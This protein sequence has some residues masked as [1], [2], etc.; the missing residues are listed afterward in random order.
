MKFQTNR[1]AKFAL[2]V[3]TALSAVGIVSAKAASTLTSPETSCPT[4]YAVIPM[5]GCVDPTPVP[6]PAPEVPVPTPAAP[7]PVNYEQNITFNDTDLGVV[8]LKATDADGNPKIDFYH[9]ETGTTNTIYTFS[10]TQADVAP[11]MTNHPAVNTLIA[12]ADGVSVYVLTT[13]EIQVNAGPDAEGK[14][15]V[16]IFN[17]IPWTSVYGYTIDP[18]K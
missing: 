7:A 12:S 18:V 16:K 14:V 15:H 10:V 4:A 3:T 11:Y 8:M 1:I 17:G 6:T 9:L 5:G 2:I 13:G